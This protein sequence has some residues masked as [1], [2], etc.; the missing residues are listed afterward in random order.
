MTQE[1]P[2][3]EIVETAP[4]DF[5]QNTDLS[6]LAMSNRLQYLS[7]RMSEG[8]HTDDD[9]KKLIIEHTI[10]QVSGMYDY[11]TDNQKQFFSDAVES[12]EEQKPI[13]IKIESE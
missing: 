3:V 13:T 7:D 1:E 9:N 6:Y 11:M 10:Q 4:V 2:K 12:M 5:S 8:W